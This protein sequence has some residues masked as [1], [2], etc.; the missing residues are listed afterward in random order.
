MK[1]IMRILVLLPLLIAKL[2]TAELHWENQHSKLTLTPKQTTGKISFKARNLSEQL[3]EIDRVESSCGCT[4]S[5]I[6]RKRLQPG[7]KT[8]VV[9]QF[10]KKGR[11]QNSQVQLQVY[12]K[13]QKEACTTLSLAVEIHTAISLKPAIV[14]WRTG[15]LGATRKLEV[16]LDPRYADGIGEIEYDALKFELKTQPSENSA[17]CYHILIKPLA[18]AIPFQASIAVHSK[19]KYGYASERAVFHAFIR[20]E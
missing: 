9:A 18:T 16:V 19:A 10:E 7:Q 14:Y 4:V 11:R 13:G 2:W 3:L 1:T 5:E 6:T 8:E 20:P 17:N 15:D 12:L